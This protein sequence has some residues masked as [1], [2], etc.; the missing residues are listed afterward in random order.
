MSAGPTPALPGLSDAETGRDRLPRERPIHDPLIHDPLIHDL[1]LR[2]HVRRVL[3]ALLDPRS[4]GSA[5]P[6]RH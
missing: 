5:P 4:V 6:R 1:L 2:E 3:R